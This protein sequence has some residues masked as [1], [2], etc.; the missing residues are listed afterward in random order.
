MFGWLKR[1]WL[2]LTTLT[3]D[4]LFD[5][6]AYMHRTSKKAERARQKALRRRK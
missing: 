6:Y 2:R 4:D 1:W 3:N 5:T